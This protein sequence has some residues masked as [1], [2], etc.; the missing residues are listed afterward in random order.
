MIGLII[1]GILIVLIVLVLVIPIGL[2]IFFEDD[3][4]R[5]SAK[6]AGI[7]L[8]LFPRAPADPTKPKK[9]K[10][11]K[12]EKEK[13]PKEPKEKKNGKKRKLKLTLDDVFDLIRVV[14][15]G[16]RNFGRKWKVERFLLHY[17]AAGQDPCKTA[18]TFG[19]VNAMLDTLAPICSQRFDVK[20]CSVWTAVD[21]AADWMRLDFGLTVTIRI[22][23]ILGSVLRIAF[24][25]IKILLR[26]RK[27][28]KLD[29]TEGPDDNSSGS[30]E[31]NAEQN[32][33][34]IEAKERMAANG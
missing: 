31:N 26:C 28:A 8:Q 21:F 13:K 19:K 3:V 11:P 15:K 6:V 32:E 14:L 27:R 4:F 1:L 29:D 2:D 20:D 5:L 18:E 34:N 7:K 25:A 30:T 24:G 22:G 10:K 16:L 23:Q 9:E 33:K 17:V 12:P